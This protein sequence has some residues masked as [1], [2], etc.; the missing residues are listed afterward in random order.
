MKNKYIADWISK[1]K[2]ELFQQMQDCVVA[3]DDEKWNQL[4]GA[5]DLLEEFNLYIFSTYIPREK[6]EVEKAAGNE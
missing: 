2:S 5:Y 1:R 3:D 6:E 4:K